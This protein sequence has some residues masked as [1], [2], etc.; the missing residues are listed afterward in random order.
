MVKLDGEDVGAADKWGKLPISLP[1][2]DGEAHW[3]EVSA[4]GYQPDRRC[5]STMLGVSDVF[6]ELLR[7]PCE[8]AIRTTPPQAEVW[9]DDELKGLSP[10]SLSLLSGQKV[11]LVIKRQGHVAVSRE[12]TVSP[13]G[14]PQELHFALQA[15]GPVLTIETDPSGAEIRV[16][17]ILRGVAPVTVD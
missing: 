1:P 10:L 2:D 17:D 14:R 3:L 4:D 6:I 7:K 12:L 5:V 16:E 15:V 8:L 9:L 11:G 13:E